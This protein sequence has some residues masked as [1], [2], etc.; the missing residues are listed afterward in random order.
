MLYDDDDI[1]CSKES[2]ARCNQLKNWRIAKLSNPYGVST[3]SNK[4]A[5]AFYRVQR[6]EKSLMQ[7]YD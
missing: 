7:Q 3:I 1:A 5:I 6:Y 2:S 4:T